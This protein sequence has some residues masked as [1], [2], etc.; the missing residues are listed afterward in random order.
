MAELDFSPVR[1]KKIAHFHGELERQI[2]GDRIPLSAVYHHSTVPVPLDQT[3][4]LP[5]VPIVEGE[6]WGR[7]WESGYFLLTARVPEAW[8]GQSVAAW[9]DFGGEGLIYRPSGEPL[10]GITNGS[11][12]AEHYSKDIYR[13]LPV[14]EGGEAVE[15]WVEAA[16]NYIN[17]GLKA[18]P[19]PADRND[20]G[21]HGSW[22]AR[23]NK[24]RL[25]VFREE[26][27]H[28]FLDMRY[29]MQLHKTLDPRSVRARRI[30]RAL[31]ESTLAYRGDASNAGAC[32]ALLTPELQKPANASAL[33]TTVVG[34]AHIDTAW[35]WRLGESH[36]KAVRTFASQIDLIRRYPGY[37]FGAS[38]PQHHQW[39]KDEQPWLWEQIRQAVAEGRWE[40]QGAMWIEADCNLISGE[41]MVRQIL[42]GKNFWKDEFGVEV[43]NCWIPDVFG[44]SAAMPQILTK[45]G[46]DFFL[47]QK[48]CWSQVNRFPH[49][50]FWWQGIDGSRVLSHLTA[51]PTYNSFCTPGVLAKAEK[52]FLENDIL[53]EF[54]T[55]MGM[56]D[57]GGGPK[58]E[59]LEHVLR[60]RDVEGVP[61]VRYGRADEFFQRLALRS[62]ALETWVGELYLEYHR[63]TYTTQARTKLNN[64]RLEQRL[65]AV[66]ALWSLLP[67]D[68]Y[69]R[70]ELDRV[71]KV[72]LLHQFHDIIPGSSIHAV[73]EDAEEAYA[74]AF[75]QLDGLEARAAQ[76]LTKTEPDTVTLANVLSH[77]WTGTVALPAAGRWV[78]QNGQPVA[79]QS[80]EGGTV[81]WVRLP[82]L[83]L[84]T[85]RRQSAFSEV[86]MPE[87]ADRS[88]PA[89]T[90]LENDEVFYRFDAEGRLVQ[91]LLKAT[92][93]SLLRPG[94][95]G[96]RLSLY[97]DVPHD[98]EAWELDYY[99]RQQWLEDA[100]VTCF[101][102]LP[103]GPV[104]QGLR[105]ELTIGVSTVVQEVYLNRTGTSLEFHTE[106]DWREA[107]RLLRVSFPLAVHTAEAVCDIQFG[108]AKRPTHSNT[109]WDAARFEVCAHRYVDL[110]DHGG[111]AAL[112]NDS[113]YGYSIQNNVLDL[114]LLRSPLHPDPDA[115]VGRHRFRYDFVPHTGGLADSGI[116]EAAA[117]VNQPPVVLE[118]AVKA[119]LDRWPFRVSGGTVSLEVVKKAEKDESWILRLVETRGRASRCRLEVGLSGVVRETDLMEWNDQ[120]PLPP[121]TGWDLEFSPFEIRTFRVVPTSS[122][123]S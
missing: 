7:T 92:G 3:R 22:E 70:A 79:A 96:N 78:D 101:V 116:I 37:V 112:V 50:T 27:W 98:Y 52:E 115:D 106:V 35:L 10:Y 117:S 65:R 63:G 49:H 122:L 68:A 82:A 59:H 95:T 88:D 55:L 9:L 62:S 6:L 42:H 119:G 100:R 80:E 76:Q 20:P 25:C 73:Y 1:Q 13:L 108:Y 113:K 11:A 21:R 85:F 81:G 120:A 107:R 48:M 31:F 84:A 94:E 114:A 2:L 38:A 64:R 56:G 12:F 44:Y 8:K 121:G 32:R 30:E 4:E 16:A 47:T 89:E 118:G 104:R 109:S 87:S 83:S 86:P 19:S 46:I 34:H 5:R 33:T 75:A 28:F 67:L 110:S 91:A 18:P 43:R 54:I 102:R 103:S 14:C 58:E 97:E 99:Y 15:L 57:G 74:E 72:L 45:S 66:E 23:V 71:V 51:E 53:D 61:K 26:V 60:G 24:I 29:L 90:I 39:I 111:G 36:R 69:P 123:T 40:P 93:R 105:W 77:E 17:Y 41:S